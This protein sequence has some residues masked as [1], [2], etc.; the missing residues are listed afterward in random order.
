MK[1]KPALKTTPPPRR[2]SLLNATDAHVMKA[3]KQASTA[4]SKASE[5]SWKKKTAA[6]NELK[7]ASAA[8][9]K[10]MQSKVGEGLS[11]SRLRLPKQR[12]GDGGGRKAIHTARALHAIDEVSETIAF[13]FAHFACFA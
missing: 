8:A 12:R 7:R 3:L 5:E 6:V 1:M 4:E 2:N 9:N 11:G 10:A 13:R